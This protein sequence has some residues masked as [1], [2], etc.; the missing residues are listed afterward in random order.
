MTSRVVNDSSIFYMDFCPNCSNILHLDEY[1][2]EMRY[3][4]HVCPYFSAVKNVTLASRSFY[5]LKV[6]TTYYYGTFLCFSGEIESLEKNFFAARVV[7][8]GETTVGE[9][10]IRRSDLVM[11]ISIWTF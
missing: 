4:C 9:I 5:K 1:M 6:N 2:G 3:K 11:V 10:G 7:F 8:D